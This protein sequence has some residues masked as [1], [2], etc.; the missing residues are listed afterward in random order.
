MISTLNV[1]CPAWKT[2]NAHKNKRA[3]G[4]L[5]GNEPRPPTSWALGYV[6]KKLK[7]FEYW[8]DNIG[9]EV[10]AREGRTKEWFFYI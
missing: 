2:R 3:E 10:L 4:Q 9:A 6:L 5:N 8:N 1:W 7:C